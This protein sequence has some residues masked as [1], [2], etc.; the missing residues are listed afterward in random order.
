MAIVTTRAQQAKIGAAARK[1]GG[2]RAL[3]D[4]AEKRRAATEAAKAIG[5][6]A[7]IERDDETGDWVVVTRAKPRRSPFAFKSIKHGR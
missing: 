7:K 5:S 2:Y 3:I 4:L 1:V 6:A